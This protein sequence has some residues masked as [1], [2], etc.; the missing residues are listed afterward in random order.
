MTAVSEELAVEWRNFGSTT[1]K[2]KDLQRGFEPD[3]CFYFK[4]EARMRGKKRLDLSRDPPPDLVLEVDITHP[5]LN[6]L[7]LFAAF[8]IAEVW[9]FDGS[10]IEF[11][12]LDRSAYRKTTNSLALPWL[13]SE[14]ATKSVDESLS[15]GRLEWLKKLRA[16]A[17]DVKV[18]QQP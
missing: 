11:Y 1:F 4:N 13:N 8:G 3:S 9:R 12:A 17:Q 7:P 14:T 5:T 16:W 2:R 6:K 18:S 10:S 15:I